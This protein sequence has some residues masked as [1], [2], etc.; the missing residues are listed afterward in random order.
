MK[1]KGHYCYGCDEFFHDSN[2]NVSTHINCKGT[3]S[4]GICVDGKEFEEGSSDFNKIDID[5]LVN[6][7]EDFIDAK[8]DYKEK[9]KNCEYDRGYF[10]SREIDR[11]NEAKNKLKETLDTYIKQVK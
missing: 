9:A 3:P 4:S 7:F 8:N 5:D 11:V 2:P 1:N 10:L 6:A